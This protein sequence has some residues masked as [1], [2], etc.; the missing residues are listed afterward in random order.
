MVA[1]HEQALT[2]SNII[3]VDFKRKRRLGQKKC[4]AIKITSFTEDAH[5]TIPRSFRM[6]ARLILVWEILDRWPG[7]D[8]R[9]LKVRSVDDVIYFLRHDLRR[10]EW[11]V[12]E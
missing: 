1:R 3:P 9:Y 6:D 4:A 8:Y 11:S 5:G 7:Q 2:V 10:N 12:L